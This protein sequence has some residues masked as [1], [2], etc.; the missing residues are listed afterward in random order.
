MY[1]MFRELVS[2]VV[3]DIVALFLPRQRRSGIFISVKDVY[4]CK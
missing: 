4:S 2:D 1:F 3:D